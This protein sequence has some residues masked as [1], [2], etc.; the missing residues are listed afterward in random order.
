MG[1]MSY[2]YSQRDLSRSSLSVISISLLW[3]SHPFC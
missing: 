2:K 3:H 1:E